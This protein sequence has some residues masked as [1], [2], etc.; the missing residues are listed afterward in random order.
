MN[1]QLKHFEKTGSV[2]NRKM[3]N[4]KELS[5]IPRTLLVEHKTSLKNP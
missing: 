2:T 3:P 5:D 4:I 1:Q